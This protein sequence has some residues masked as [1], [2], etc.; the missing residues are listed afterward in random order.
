MRNGEQHLVHVLC[1][2]EDAEI[3]PYTYPD[4]KITVTT[5]VYASA[6][7]EVY[8]AQ[9]IAKREQVRELDAE[10]RAKRQEVAD[11]AKNKA[12]MEKA[13]AKYPCI[14][15]ALAFIEGRITHVVTHDYG[16][17]KIETLK[18]AF[19][20]KDTWGT[21][22]GMKL[23]NLFGTDEKGRST[24]WGLNRYRDGSGG[25]TQIW[26]AQSEDEARHIVSR[27]LDDALT[28][29]RS[30]EK[31]WQVGTVS[32][33]ETLNRNP[34]LTAP[35]D[36]LAHIAAREA[37]QKAQQIANLRAELAQMEGGA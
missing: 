25:Y 13:A 31:N 15:Q 33:P 1:E 6:P 22:E 7:V 12:A 21:Y 10:L 3:G 34:W 29:W 19:E 23:L 20:S 24:A 8:D 11:A 2:I 26:P 14:Q 37:E 17:A 4:D 36:W 35:D 30:G 5:K 9:V 32:I 18:E 16:G 27:L 28:A